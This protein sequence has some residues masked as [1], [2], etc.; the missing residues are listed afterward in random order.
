[1]TI[2][3]HREGARAI[4]S[5]L[6][7]R[8]RSELGPGGRATGVALAG[9]LGPAPGRTAQIS[10]TLGNRSRGRQDCDRA[11]RR[12][13]ADENRT[14]YGADRRLSGSG[15]APGSVPMSNAVLHLGTH[16]WQVC[17]SARRPQETE[18][19]RWLGSGAT[20]GLPGRC[21]AA[22]IASGPLAPHGE[23]W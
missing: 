5:M 6:T 8:L 10:C 17:E 14:F 15:H 7:P 23:C 18:E 3:R 20:A 12:F 9:W 22:A 13:G 2:S 19:G 1:M 11:E 16:R 4:A 21:G